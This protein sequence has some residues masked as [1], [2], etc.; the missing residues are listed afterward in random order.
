[1][2][3]LTEFNVTR[4]QSIYGLVWAIGLHTIGFELLKKMWLDLA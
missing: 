1:M 4:Q 3:R 2:H